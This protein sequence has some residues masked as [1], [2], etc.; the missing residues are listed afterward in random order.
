MNQT[1]A[2]SSQENERIPELDGLRGFAILSVV[3]LHYFYAPRA[4]AP[5]AFQYFQNIFRLGWVGVDLFFVLSG[6]L[7]GGILLRARAATNYYRVFY[8]RRFF[9]IIPIYYLWVAAYILIIVLLGDFIRRHTNS[10]VAAPL[11]FGIYQHFFFLQNIHIP[12][13]IGLSLWWFGALWSLAVEEQFY[14]LSPLLVRRLSE[15][16][17][18]WVLLA[19][20]CAAPILRTYFYLTQHPLAWRAVASTPCRADSL[21]LGMLA[22]ILWRRPAFRAWLALHRRLFLALWGFFLLGMAALWYRG[23]NPYHPATLTIGFSWIAVFFFLTLLLTLGD[24]RGLFARCARW[25]WLREL[26]R[27]SYCVYVIHLAVLYV[28]FGAVLRI[29]PQIRDFRCIALSLFCAVV[30]FLV[31]RLSWSF[32]EHP[33]L[34]V[35]HRA[36]YQFAPEPPAQHPSIPLKPRAPIPLS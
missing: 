33:L 30:T 24:S 25:R 11:G 7:I 6:F 17:L 8:A 9:R 22:A 26:G 5:P 14:L 36:Q 34:R 35:G 21:A 15:R 10:G 29:V 16:T 31:A 19:I 4:L 2:L 3:L 13:Q 27:V 28:A 18:F 1:E 23:S 12:P 20:F 32:L